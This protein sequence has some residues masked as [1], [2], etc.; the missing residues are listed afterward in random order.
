MPPAN[1]LSLNSTAAPTAP[2]SAIQISAWC[3]LTSPEG[4]GRLRVRSTW[5]STLRSRMSFQV[6]P[7][8]RMASA[9]R[10]NSAIRPASLSQSGAAAS[11]SDHQQG[12]SSSQMPIGRS[13]RASRP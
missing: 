4:S 6:Q 2:C 13:Q 5:A 3:S 8:P 9:P 12:N 10:A 11:A 1:L 7:A